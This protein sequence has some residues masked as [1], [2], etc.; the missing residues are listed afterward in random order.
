MLIRPYF[1][2]HFDATSSRKIVLGPR[3][4][5]SRQ[6]RICNIYLDIANPLTIAKIR[7]RRQCL[8]E[9]PRNQFFIFTAVVYSGEAVDGA[10]L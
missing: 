8:A 6:H 9:R 2:L 10:L 1:S 4:G 5:S 3:P 7:T